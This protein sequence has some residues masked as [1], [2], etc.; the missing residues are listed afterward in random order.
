M[1]VRVRFAPS[2]TGRLHIGGVR[3]ALF[4]W[5]FARH[6]RGK[7]ILRIEDTDRKRSTKESIADILESMKWLGLEWDEGPYLQMDRLKIYKKYG[8]KLL[9]E[10]KAYFCY[11]TPEEL[12]DRR[13]KGAYR[14][15]GR[16]RNL[17][18]EQKRKYTR[19]GRKPALRLRSPSTGKTILNDII[20]GRIEFENKLLD[21]FVL[22]K[23]DSVPTYNFACIIDD[24]LMKI[25]HVI[26][27]ED[28]LSNT[29]RQ[30]LVYQ[31]LGFELPEFTHLPLILGSDHTPLSKRH[32]AVA[33]SQYKEMGYLPQAL[34][35]YL[36]LLGWG[37]PESKQL[38]TREE[39]IERFSLEHVSRNPAVFDPKKLEWLNGHYL[40]ETDP[41]EITDLVIDYLK[42]NEL[43]LGEID[44]EKR[45]WIERIV[46][47]VGE[48][49]KYIGQII[50]YAGFF[51]TEKITLDKKAKEKFLREEI[52]PF[53]K[54]VKEKLSELEEFKEKEIEKI[55]REELE[56]FK[57]KPKIGA[58]AIRVALT[59]QTISPPLFETIE[60]LGKERT[61][62]RLKKVL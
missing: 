35:N 60:L 44:P 54:E 24:V 46:G 33:V 53:L 38:F 29:P 18:E 40:K 32:G 27:G 57:L 48:R 45:R 26:R 14:Y 31:A 8:D 30:I 3:T 20:R 62:E 17:T 50:D 59:G 19:Q 2:S 21:D 58:Q 28:H 13:R 47:T 41:E 55:I 36:A 6:H 51:F 4:N 52:K 56:V 42:K 39:L 12:K 37:T 11:C 22:L 10:E 25:T 7:F 15:D 5:L 61:I 34:I 23:S 43:L 1:E 9:E 49:L 16:C